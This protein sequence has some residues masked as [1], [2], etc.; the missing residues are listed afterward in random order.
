MGDIRTA[1]LPVAGL[2]TRFLPA[3]RAIPKELLP[4]VDRPLVHYALDEAQAAG[5]ERFVFV[6]A[7]GKSV[8]EDHFDRNATLEHFLQQTGKLDLLE[9]CRMDVPPPGVITYVR[10]GNP[11][12]LGHAVL[13]ARH[14]VGEEPFAVLLPDDVILGQ[15]PA[16]AALIDAR[17]KLGP[18]TYT[19]VKTVAPEET[20]RYGIVR[21]AE[22]SVEQGSGAVPVCGLVEKPDPAA[23]PSRLA[24]VG[25]YLLE[26]ETFRILARQDR[27]VGGEIQLTDALDVLAREGRAWAVPVEGERFDCGSKIGLLKANV[28]L[29]LKDPDLGPRLR[30]FL[31]SLE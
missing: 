26:P 18:G 11:R 13:A 15:R 27:G 30:A 10:Q 24:C 6:T 25:R 14:A 16:L 9:R 28:V 7:R 20:H 19:G 31:R 12:G 1:V 4:I 3:T 17:E 23:A 22:A 29:A 2:G 21:P 8:I 5:I